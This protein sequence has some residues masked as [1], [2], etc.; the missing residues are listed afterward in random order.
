MKLDDA[1]R[2]KMIQTAVAVLAKEY[3]FPDSV[4]KIEKKLSANAKAKRYDVKSPEKLAKLLTDDFAE[5]T[6]LQ[7]LGVEYSADAYPD[8]KPIEH[9]S[10]AD[11]RA[12]AR[13]H[14]A[15]FNG[16]IDRV[17]RLPG[18]IGYIRMRSI[19]RP[20]GDSNPLAAA[21]SFVADTEELIV[22]LRDCMEHDPEATALVASYF[23]DADQS[24]R[25]TTMSWRANESTRDY[26]T[27][28]DVSGRRY[29][30]PVYVLVN[31]RTQGSAEDLA[32][33]VQ[34]KKRGKVV[35]E[36]TAGA[37]YD[38]RRRKLAPNFALFVPVGKSSTKIPIKPD[39]KADDA[40]EAAYLAALKS[41][42]KRTDPKK[43]PK[44][45]LPN[46]SDELDRALEK[47][48]KKTATRKRR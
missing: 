7:T 41:V 43:M 3:V 6:K 44:G 24:L 36:P 31:G 18:N 16:F 25:V 40:F 35:G 34:S 42:R 9:A 10:S 29:G 17:E 19:V 33:F 45:Y 21:M 23:V 48:Q 26:W 22:D 30:K 15:Q 37:T 13:A 8:D 32:A 28:P 5:I 46:F 11:D 1:L 27:L 2:D 12:R 39:I 20:F 47:A 38:Y 4:G 14:A